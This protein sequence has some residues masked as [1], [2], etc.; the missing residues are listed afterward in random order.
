MLFDEVFSDPI[1]ERG[2]LELPCFTRA[3][4]IALR[5]GFLGLS[6]PPSGVF[7][8]LRELRLSFVRFHG[9]LTLDDTVMPFLEGLE[10]YSARVLASLTL[11]LKHLNW[12]NLSAVRGLL[13]LNAVVPRLKFLTVSCCFCS[14]TWLV[15]MAGVCIVAEELQVLRWLDWYCP[16]LIKFSQMP[17]LYVLSV[18]PFYPYGRHRQHTK[19]NPSCDRLLKTFS[20]IRCLEMLVFIEP[21]LG[22]VNPLM[23]GITRLPDI[24]FLHLQFSA[25]GHVYGASVLYMLTMCTGISNLKIGGDRYKDQDVCPPNCSCDRPPNWRDNKDISMRSLREVQMLNFR[26]KE[27]EL[28]LL[29]VLVRVATG[30]RRIRITCH[31]SF[32]AWERL[33]AV[34]RSFARPETSV[35]VSQAPPSLQRQ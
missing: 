17:R 8:A 23:E 7:A 34:I 26:G 12:M 31:R 2:A 14:S 27:H 33:S 13:R 1:E 15:A 4:K 20:R 3:T 28:D 21:H 16:R 5:L 9:E 30:I 6:L 32:A 29:R 19:F 18:S 25:H 11:R 22:G 35:E 24:R 10:I